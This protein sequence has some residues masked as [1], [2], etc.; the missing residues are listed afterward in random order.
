[1]TDTKAWNPEDLLL[2]VFGR[3]SQENSIS[4]LKTSFAFDYIPTN[5]YQANSAYLQISQMVY[6]LATSM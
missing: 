4:E 1:V 5:T 3:S 2:F 6:N